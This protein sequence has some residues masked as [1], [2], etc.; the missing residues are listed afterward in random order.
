MGADLELY[1]Q[2]KDG[3]EFPIEISLSPL[4]THQGTLVL[5]A[6]RDVTNLKRAQEQLRQRAE[7]V[8]KLM[9]VAPV[10]LLVAHDP[11]CHEITGNR[12]GKCHVRRR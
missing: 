2:C 3:S 6:I 7:E 12:A 9:D 1:G 11:E 4:M 10:A 8:Q 5:S